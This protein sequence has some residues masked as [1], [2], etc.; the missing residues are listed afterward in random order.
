MPIDLELE[1]DE[2]LHTWHRSL[3]NATACMTSVTSINPEHMC[4]SQPF[5]CWSQMVLGPASVAGAGAIQKVH[6]IH[7]VGAVTSAVQNSDENSTSWCFGQHSTASTPVFTVSTH[8]K[9]LPT[10]VPQSMRIS[11]CS[12]PSNSCFRL[13]CNRWS[14]YP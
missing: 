11:S 2:R 7:P 12:C 10:L 9:P 3:D 14:E 5:H 8:Y 6:N 1:R 13:R 4:F